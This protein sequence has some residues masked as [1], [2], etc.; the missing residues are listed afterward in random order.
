MNSINYC[1]VP[2]WGMPD[3]G[4]YYHIDNSLRVIRKNIVYTCYYKTAS[5]HYVGGRHGQ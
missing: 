2:L 1:T 3:S 4:S 5:F